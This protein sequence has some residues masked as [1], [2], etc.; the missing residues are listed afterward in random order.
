MAAFYGS[1]LL[2]VLNGFVL[3]ECVIRKDI[4]LLH[5]ITPTPDPLF[6][7]LT[8]LEILK[9]Q[10]HGCL[11]YRFPVISLPFPSSHCHCSLSQVRDGSRLLRELH[12]LGSFCLGLDR[13]LWLDHSLWFGLDGS[14]WLR[15]DGSLDPL[16]RI[17]NLLLELVL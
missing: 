1:A 5:N 14:L 3:N 4:I 17:A 2:A 9:S 6:S 8:P 11:G 16:L 12:L 10:A 7:Q 15:L 13:S